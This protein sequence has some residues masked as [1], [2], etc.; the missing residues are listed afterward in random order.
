MTW[1]NESDRVMTMRTAYTCKYR[2]QDIKYRRFL[3][4][5]GIF[6]IADGELYGYVENS[7]SM[8]FDKTRVRVWSLI[9]AQYHLKELFKNRKDKTKKY[10]IYRLTRRSSSAR[11]IADFSL[12]KS[13]TIVKFDWRNIPFHKNTDV[14]LACPFCGKA[15]ELKEASW[16]G[17]E[18]VRCPNKECPAKPDTYRFA[19]GAYKG[20]TQGE[21]KQWNIKTWNTRYTNAERDAQTERT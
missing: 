7:F 8:S 17:V 18:Y 14:L 13:P 12:W 9:D 21:A 2:N 15:A 10:F 4:L 16:T 11:I 20:M 3:P 19:E 1:E 5:Y 6:C